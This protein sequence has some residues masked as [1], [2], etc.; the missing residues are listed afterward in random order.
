MERI[1]KRLGPQHVKR[2]LELIDEGN[3]REAFG[4]ALG[5]YDR[6]YQYNLKEHNTGPITE[7]DGVGLTYR[8]LAVKIS[9]S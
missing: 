9:N 1:G 6:A 3:L 5:Y 7:I 2:A 8:D 4:I